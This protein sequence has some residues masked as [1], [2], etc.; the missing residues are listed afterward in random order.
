MQIWGDRRDLNPRVPE[1][2]SGALTNFATTAM[3]SCKG[4]FTVF[5]LFCK[6]LSSD[7]INFISIFQKHRSL[8]T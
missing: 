8:F 4:N 2:Q 3:S 7:F 6:A 1:P 5:K